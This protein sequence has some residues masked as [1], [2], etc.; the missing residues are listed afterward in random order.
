MRRARFL[1]LTVEL[2]RSGAFQWVLFE[3]FDDLP[4]F[5]PFARSD[6][7]FTTYQSAWDAGCEALQSL[8]AE[9]TLDLLDDDDLG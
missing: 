7:S 6:L 5:E 8:M 9:P 2:L 3:S 4:G 1:V